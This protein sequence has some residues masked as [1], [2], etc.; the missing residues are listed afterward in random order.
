MTV[1]IL[2]FCIF[3]L[4]FVADPILNFWLDPFGSIVD[5]ISDVVTDIDALKESEH[6]E[7]S[8]WSLHFLKGLFS[9]GIL[10]FVKS[11]LAM[12]PWQWFRFRSPGIG[13]GGRR[14]GTGRDR[15]QHI[16]WGLVLIGLVTFL[17]AVWK[18][19]SH[20]CELVLEKAKEK[21]VDVQGD[22]D[23]DEDEVDEGRATMPEETRKNI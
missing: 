1:V 8:T 23:D 2:L 14:G 10:G 6:D 16:N 22:D 3:L 17:T 7:P 21:V 20:Y 19:V 4:G 5:T 13:V 9:L 11:F 15:L 18:L 12:T